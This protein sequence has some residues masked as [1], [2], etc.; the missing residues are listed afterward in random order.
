MGI[1]FDVA[2]KCTEEGAQLIIVSRHRDDLENAIKMVNATA[3]KHIYYAIDVSQQDKVKNMAAD[4][5]KNTNFID[6]LVNCAG[7]YGPIG[8]TDEINPLEFTNA[9]NINLL[10][11]FYMCY[12]FIPL[13]KKSRRG[14]IVNYSG[15]GAANAFPNYAAYAV[16]KTGIVRFSENLALEFKNDDIDINAIA[17]GFVI[18]RL[19]QETLKAGKKAGE[20]FFKKTIDQINKGGIPSDMAV[21]L[22]VFLLSSNS[23]GITG[24]FISAPW[25]P[26]QDEKFQAKLKNDED[27]ATL[28]RID[29]KYFSKKG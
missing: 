12:Y 28:R 9:I 21:K 29:D 23:D 15:G 14:K 10:G 25:D 27:F 18:T 16:S 6:G 20:E 4:I 3:K 26:W 17:P 8:K 11:T 22:T 19:H 13:L 2:K 5:E 7:I 1:G 24:K